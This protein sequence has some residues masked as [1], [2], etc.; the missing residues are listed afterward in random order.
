MPSNTSVSPKSI[1][2]GT[3][4]GIREDMV[5]LFIEEDS[6][7]K[8][9]N[10]RAYEVVYRGIST[11]G[12]E[13]K[14]YSFTIMNETHIVTAFAIAHSDFDNTIDECKKLTRTVRIK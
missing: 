10:F 4:K 11:K 8:I 9:N 5:E 7:S 13:V 1:S 6:F 14:V 12:D 3:I 2:L